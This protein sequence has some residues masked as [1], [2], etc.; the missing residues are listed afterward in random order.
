MYYVHLYNTVDGDELYFEFA[1]KPALSRFMKWTKS[2][3]VRTRVSDWSD[4]CT[5]ILDEP[6][7]VATLEIAKGIVPFKV[8]DE[9]DPGNWMFVFEAN[10]VFSANAY[11]EELRDGFLELNPMDF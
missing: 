4:H 8:E 7:T 6:A 2:F 5:I 11:L 1:D 9:L 3:Y 10:D